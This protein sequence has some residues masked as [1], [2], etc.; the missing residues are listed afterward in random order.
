MATA[1][2]AKAAIE[3]GFTTYIAELEKAGPVWEKKPTTSGEGEDAWCAR[4][5]AEHIGG[6][7]LF[8]GSGIATAMGITGPTPSRMSFPDA[9]TALAETRRTHGELMA[10]VSQV[11]DEQL[12]AETELR[13]LGKQTVGGMLGIVSYHL[14]DHANQL[15]TLRGG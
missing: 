2:E 12:A 5:V 6:S 3:A 7:G 14:N 4:Q 13:G 1:E 9:A 15:K 11:K 8:F 10:V